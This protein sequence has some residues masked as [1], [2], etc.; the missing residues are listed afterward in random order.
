MK[1][2]L[3]PVVTGSLSVLLCV[4]ALVFVQPAGAGQPAFDANTI[5]EGR[6]IAVFAGGCFWCMEPPFDALDGVEETIVG[7]TGG[8]YER[9]SYRIVAHTDTGHY[10]AVL[11]VFDPSRVS[12]EELLEVFWINVN[13]VDSTG[14]FCDRGDS[15][16]SAIFA[17]DAAQA[18]AADATRR[19]LDTSGHLLSY[20]RP[21]A[22]AVLPLS[23]FW[24]A[25]EYHQD[26]Y[27][28]HSFN[29]RYYRSRCGRDDRLEALWGPEDGRRT[30][31][32]RLIES[33]R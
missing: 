16:R 12:Y 24:V 28:N 4:S 14:Q 32:R 27:L 31:I 23:T 17:A 18:D 5:P 29:Y 6:S 33:E 1:G 21:I 30:L 11:V 7:Y 25:E 8:H 13:P 10:E 19:A 3:S 22:T 20:D 2:R 9:P 26:Y 15:Y